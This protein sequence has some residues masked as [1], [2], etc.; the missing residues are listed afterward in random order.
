MTVPEASEP[1]TKGRGILTWYLPSTVRGS[2]QGKKAGRG[3]II[4]FQVKEHAV[5]GW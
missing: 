3:A 4:L 1:G 5:D 2:V